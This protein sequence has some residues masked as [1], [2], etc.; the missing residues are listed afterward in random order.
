MAETEK[1]MTILGGAATIPLRIP[2]GE[3]KSPPR[4]PVEKVIT[5][6]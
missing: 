2:D 1:N 3:I 4:I 6:I 5:I